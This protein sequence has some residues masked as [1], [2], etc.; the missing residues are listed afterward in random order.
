MSHSRANT[1]SRSTAATP[2]ARSRERARRSS[3]RVLGTAAGMVTALALLGT[4]ARAQEL[5]LTRDLPT[6]AGTACASVLPLAPAAAPRPAEARRLA[7]AAS[8][9]ALAGELTAARDQLQRA[10]ALDP[11]SAE[12]QFQLGRAH[13]ALGDRPEALRAYCRTQRLSRDPEELAEVQQRI[14]QLAT[15]QGRLPSERAAVS[16]RTGVAYAESG[17]LAAAERAFG[18]AVQAAPNFAEAYYNRALVR[19]GVGLNDGALDDLDRLAR[20]APDG[21]RAEVREARDVLRSGRQSP[22]TALGL[23]MVLPGGG[24]FYTGRPYIG[25]VVALVAVAGVLVSQEETV[26]TREFTATDPFG[27]PYTYER[28]VAEKPRLALGLG[29][30]AGSLIGGALEAFFRARGAQEEVQDLR[31]TVRAGLTPSTASRTGTP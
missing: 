14:A 2:G 12:L 5:R 17:D 27:N 1:R 26:V 15:E 18:E 28:G 9:S 4:P 30:V 10:V 29:M 21:H 20:L 16:F 6:A 11:A 3:A 31:S 24:Q 13:D 7:D 25:A 19:I 23:G 8:V 22:T